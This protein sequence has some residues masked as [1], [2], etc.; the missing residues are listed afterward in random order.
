[1]D[2]QHSLRMLCL[3]AMLVKKKEMSYNHPGSPVLTPCQ[4]TVA[5]DERS[6]ANVLSP[7]SVNTTIAPGVTLS[8]SATAVESQAG[9]NGET[10]IRIVHEHTNRGDG[11]AGI[12]NNRDFKI[13]VFVGKN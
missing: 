9:S 12:Y 11:D 5:E 3:L 7:A 10:T 6:L 1:M 4:S 8:T 13:P 2:T